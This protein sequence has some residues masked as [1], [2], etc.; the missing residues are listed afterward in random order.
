MRFQRLFA[1]P[2]LLPTVRAV[3]RDAPVGDL[4]WRAPVS[5]PTTHLGTVDATAYANSC[6]A[7]NETTVTSGTS[8]DCLFVNVYIPYTTKATS[9]LSV[10]VYFHGGGFSGN[11]KDSH[12]RISSEAARRRVALDLR[13]LGVPAGAFWVLGRERIEGEWFKRPMDGHHDP[14]KPIARAIT[15]LALKSIPESFYGEVLSR[16]RQVA[17]SFANSWPVQE[18]SPGVLSLVVGK[19][20]PASFTFTGLPFTTPPPPDANGELGFRIASS[21]SR[22]A[23]VALFNPGNVVLVQS[24]VYAG[25]IPVIQSARCD[26]I[27][28]ITA[29]S[30]VVFRGR[31]GISAEPLRRTLNNWPTNKR[32]AGLV[33]DS[34][35]S[36]LPS[37]IEHD[38]RLL[39]AT[40][41]EDHL[42][43]GVQETIA[44]LQQADIKV[45]VATDDKLETAIAIRRSTNLGGKDSNTIVIGN[46][47]ERL[48]P[49]Y[50]QLVRAVKEFFSESDALKRS[51]DQRETDTSSPDVFVE[52]EQSEAV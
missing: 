35:G 14:S 19:P 28:T 18:S 47:D 7:N 6:F 50:D 9:K 23:I 24:P 46:G 48:R 4:R 42:Q 33:G 30:C 49:V 21:R 5:P 32:T 15:A 36:V 8:E 44:D 41:S 29:R 11:N 38:L 1:L 2:A 45:W 16:R 39:G 10:L 13:D 31:G 3:L 22:A 52:C 20:T 12:Q 25:I 51:P 27:G 34:Y 43:D 37:S 26:Q 17:A 40:A